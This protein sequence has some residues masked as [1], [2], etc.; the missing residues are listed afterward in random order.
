MEAS[1]TLRRHFCS[2]SIQLITPLARYIN[3]L[4][5]SPTEVQRVRQASG[6]PTSPASPLISTSTSRFS[7][8]SPS[9]SPSHSLYDSP[10][11]SSGLVHSPLSASTSSVLT[12]TQE[13]RSLDVPAFTPRQSA[14]RLKPFNNTNFFASLKAHGS[15]L[16][17]KS[18]SKRTEFYQRCAH[19]IIYLFF[20]S[21][22][23][24]VDPGIGG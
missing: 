7:L 1:L 22:A 13:Q 8:P 5:P 24:R 19:L 6:Y 15:V 21:E 11:P 16:P 2:R 17:F 23:S 12:P 4:I 9:Y 3:S 14:L 18:N 10:V 20:L